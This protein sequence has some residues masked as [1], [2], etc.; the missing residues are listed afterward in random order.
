MMVIFKRPTLMLLAE[1]V[2]PKAPAFWGVPKVVA[3]TPAA[4][5]AKGGVAGA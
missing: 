3:K 2:I 5:S 1:S 4:G